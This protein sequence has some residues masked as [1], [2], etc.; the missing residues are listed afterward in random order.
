[1]IFRGVVFEDGRRVVFGIDGDR[2]EEDIAADAVAEQALHLGEARR[3]E[4]ARV[5]AGRGNQIDGDRFSFEGMVVKAYRWSVLMGQR[6][7]REEVGCPT[8]GRRGPGGGTQP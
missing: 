3:L 6:G 2:I 7:V 1:M 4:R 8:C 5:L